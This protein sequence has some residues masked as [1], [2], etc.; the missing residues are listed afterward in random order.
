MTTLR[1]LLI[2]CR[3]KYLGAPIVAAMGINGNAQARPELAEVGIGH[4]VSEN[5]SPLMHLHSQK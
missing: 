2:C 3:F 5:T 4:N 1:E